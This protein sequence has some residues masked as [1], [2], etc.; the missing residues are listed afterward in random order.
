MIIAAT[1]AIIVSMLLILV[2]GFLGPTLYDRVLA[3]NSFGTK[4]ILMIALLGYLT[5]RPEWIDLCVV[6]AAVNFVGTIAVLK[7][8]RYRSFQLP[9]AV[10]AREGDRSN[11]DTP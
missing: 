1:A 5:D 3:G 11:G 6:Y 10:G 9:M 4:A 8:V 2:R 7:F